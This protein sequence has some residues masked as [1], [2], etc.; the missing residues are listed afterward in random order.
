VARDANPVPHLRRAP[1][2]RLPSEAR[3]LG[4]ICRFDELA[5][6]PS[7][8]GLA[9]LHPFVI[10]CDDGVVRLRGINAARRFRVRPLA[11]RMNGMRR[12]V[13]ENEYRAAT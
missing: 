7:G 8:V 10:G 12:F 3:C 6:E 5:P 13:D 2:S 9:Y 4:L 1:G 11:R